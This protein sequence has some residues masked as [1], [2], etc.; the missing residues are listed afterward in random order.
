MKGAGSCCELLRRSQRSSD[1]G[2][3]VSSLPSVPGALQG[4]ME[5]SI[6]LWG[7]LGSCYPC[8]I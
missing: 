3:A 6:Q 8:R 4:G 5:I 7:L 1:L 2:G